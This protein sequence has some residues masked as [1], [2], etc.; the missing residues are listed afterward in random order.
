MRRRGFL[1]AA[2]GGVLA[3]ALPIPATRPIVNAGVGA[4]LVVTQS[5]AL[6]GLFKRAYTN[7]IRFMR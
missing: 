6:D 2:L 3:V 1:K 5:T 4:Q 7:R